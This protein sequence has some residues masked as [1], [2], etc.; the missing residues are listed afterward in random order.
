MTWRL[1]ATSPVANGSAIVFKDWLSLVADWAEEAALKLG[2]GVASNF[3]SN[4]SSW[5]PYSL[6]SSNTIDKMFK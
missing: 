2:G 4:S 1:E 3:Y 5:A 6:M